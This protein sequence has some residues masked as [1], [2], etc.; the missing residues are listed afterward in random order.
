M[1][2][3][4]RWAWSQG[5][6]RQTLGQG[7][8]PVVLKQVEQSRSGDGNQGQPM[9]LIATQVHG[10][11][12]GP[13]PSQ[14]AKSA[15]LHGTI[16]STGTPTV[17]LRQGPWTRP[18]SKCSSRAQGRPQWGFSKLFLTQLFPS[19]R[20]QGYSHTVPELVLSTQPKLEEG[21]GC[22]ISWC[23]QGPDKALLNP[24]KWLACLCEISE[25]SVKR[26]RR[27]L[28]YY[29][30]LHPGIMS[31]IPTI[32]KRGSIP[33]RRSESSS[34]PVGHYLF[35][36]FITEG[37]Q[38]MASRPWDGTTSTEVKWHSQLK[39]ALFLAFSDGAL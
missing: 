5:P 8:G 24:T 10:D 16:L 18:E 36:L 6:T 25:I 29:L 26:S 32:C 31:N 28:L 17:Q 33:F 39:T 27:D 15:G 1:L 35:V 19:S 37:I 38:V 20:T 23:T 21:R 4:C 30:V 11:E 14:A 3:K 2:C 34:I 9:A 12:T 7:P 13:R 22:R